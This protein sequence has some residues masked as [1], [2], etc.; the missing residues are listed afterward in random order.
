MLRGKLSSSLMGALQNLTKKLKIR[1]MSTVSEFT[2][3]RKSTILVVVCQWEQS[4]R[5]LLALTMASALL[6]LVWMVLVNR[7]LSKVW[8]ER[9]HLQ[10]ETLRS[11]AL[12]CKRSSKK[13]ASW[14]ATAPNMTQYSPSWVSKRRLNSTPL[15]KASWQSRSRMRLKRLSRI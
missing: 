2:T 3:Y 6:S 11:K 10:Q 7:L 4:D 5:R 14:L 15:S 8:R 1:T 13:L 9:L 12:M